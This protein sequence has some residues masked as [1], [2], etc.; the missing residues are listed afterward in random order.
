MIGTCRLR[1]GI[2]ADFTYR[3]DF[4]I[5]LIKR[6]LGRPVAATR[7]SQI[8]EG[9][10][11]TRQTDGFC[12]LIGILAFGQIHQHGHGFPI[13]RHNGR[14]VHSERFPHPFGSFQIFDCQVIHKDLVI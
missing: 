10:T 12:Q 1:A 4:G 3:S 6:H 11:S 5:D 7:G 2:P 14:P 8:R 9:Q 13:I